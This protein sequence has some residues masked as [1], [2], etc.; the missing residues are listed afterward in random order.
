[1]KIKVPKLQSAS[2]A[3]GSIT[4]TDQNI[5]TG[6]SRYKTPVICSDSSY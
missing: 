3:V 1:M 5:Q 6:L 2:Q 4:G